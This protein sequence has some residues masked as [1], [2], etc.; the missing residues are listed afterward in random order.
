MNAFTGTPHLI[1]L[2]LRRD[3]VRL[4]IWILAITALVGATASAITGL[5]ETPEEMAGYA[6]TAD[7]PATRLM[8]GR[9]DGLDNVG[10]IT[11]YEI[12]VSGLVAVALMVTFLVVRHTRT[13]EE[14]GHAELLRATVSGRHAAMLAAA[15]VAT[16][17]SVTIGIL[18]AVV[19]VASGL[20]P[21]GSVLH[22]TV[23]A[24]VGLVFAGVAAA[25]AQLTS[26]SR[27]AL[28]IAMGV[29][30]LSFVV[31][32]VGDVADNALSWLSPLGWALLTQP[33]GAARWWLLLPLVALA[34]ALVGPTVWLT[35]HRDAGAGML[36]PRPGPA[37]ARGSLGT[38]T[39]LA[40]RLQRGSILGWTTGLV[41]GAL[42]M[43]SVGPELDDMI[44]AN[45]DLAEFFAST[46]ADPVSAFLVTAFGLLGVVAAGF[47][48]SSALRLRSEESAGRA[49]AVLATG[50]SRT[51]WALGS[52]TVTVVATV[53]IMGLIGLATAAAFA[54]ASGDSSSFGTFTAAGLALTPAVLVVAGLAVLLTGWLPRYS[55]AAFAL[56]VFAFV[57]SYLGNL[58]DLPGWLS[59]FSPFWHL[60]EMPVEDFAVGPAATVLAV[61]LG[62]GALGM[63][64][65]RRRD[66]AG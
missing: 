13:E 27:S 45:P 66:L 38:A 59:A 15:V 26:A 22:G 12:S 28:G 11:A 57:Q 42:L 8:S 10:A 61:G 7:S 50:L 1:R 35:A 56:V 44:A 9:P 48:A 37:R 43:G 46:G 19:L 51:R 49:E 25:A 32:G 39:G 47:A 5:Y 24:A 34:V 14:S 65:L 18:D 16:A 29:L 31:R 33:Y 60:A 6:S 30:A 53:V 52:L 63:V 41:L 21:G 64:G 55:S 23:L 58:L 2:I 62:L 36:H 54:A 40:W 20:D 4:P 3:R 17:A